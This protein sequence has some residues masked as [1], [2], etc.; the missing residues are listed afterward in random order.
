[1]P[2]SSIL[3]R[4]LPLKCAA[5]LTSMTRPLTLAPAG[6]ATSPLTI[7]GL[8]TTPEKDVS[9]WVVALSSVCVDAHGD[10]GAWGDSGDHDRQ[11]Q[12]G[13]GEEDLLAA[14]A[15]QA[16]T[17]E[18]HWAAEEAF[19]AGQLPDALARV[20]MRGAEGAAVVV[21]VGAMAM[22]WMVRSLTTC[23]T[24]GTLMASCAG[25][26]RAVSLRRCR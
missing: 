3:S 19:R 26:G 12:A 24:P 13:E 6:M 9:G 2:V 21:M 5:S 16:R 14:A 17:P 23:F 11:G 15:A 18:D 22:P 4:E 7:T 8:V 10:S 25:D 20:A 1:M